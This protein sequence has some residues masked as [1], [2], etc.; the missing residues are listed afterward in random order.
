[1]LLITS[2]ELL[3]LIRN[4]NSKHNI[5]G[6]IMNCTAWA[7]H[8]AGWVSTAVLSV[9]LHQ[10]SPPVHPHKPGC[11][12]AAVSSC[13]W[14]LLWLTVSVPLYPGPLRTKT[15]TQAPQSSAHQ[16]S[17]VKS[18]QLIQKWLN[19]E[20][21]VIVFHMQHERRHKNMQE[22]KLATNS[23]L[24]MIRLP[25]RELTHKDNLKVFSGA[26]T[27]PLTKTKWI[28]EYGWRI[29]HLIQHST[30]TTISK[31]IM[32]CNSTWLKKFYRFCLSAMAS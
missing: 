28:S 12:D 26:A 17:K 7:L 23:A 4:S 9:R 1:M 10:S 21:L 6:R 13:A 29:I 5:T 30:I 27:L 32:S 19:M 31:C 22:I 2:S 20:V 16:N 8:Y 14:M 15:Q 18:L 25:I 3:H 11:W 24:Q